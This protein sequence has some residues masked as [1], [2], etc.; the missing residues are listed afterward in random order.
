M[1]YVCLFIKHFLLLSKSR[2]KSEPEP[3]VTT[4]KWCT[5]THK[6]FVHTVNHK[7]QCPRKGHLHAPPQG[8]ATLFFPFNLMP[9]CEKRDQAF[10]SGNLQAESFHEGIKQRMTSFRVTAI[11]VE[12]NHYFCLTKSETITILQIHF[13]C[14][15]LI[16]SQFIK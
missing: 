1:L 12:Q 5:N 3:T 11:C 7:D 9:V 8:P 4:T 14:Q 13:I 15:K 2:L 16:W 6:L 10:C